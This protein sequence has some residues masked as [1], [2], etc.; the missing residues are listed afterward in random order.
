MHKGAVKRAE[1]AERQNRNL[2]TQLANKDLQL[3]SIRERI[4]NLDEQQCDDKTPIEET[5][6]LRRDIAQKS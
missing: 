4:I 3:K 2:E 6:R 5:S 1:E